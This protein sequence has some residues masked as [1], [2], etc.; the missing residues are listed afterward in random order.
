[1]PDQKLPVA[2]AA[3]VAILGAI[4][5]VL[6]FLPATTTQII[7]VVN[8]PKASFDESMQQLETGL[9]SPKPSV[10]ALRTNAAEAYRRAGQ[11]WF[12]RATNWKCQVVDLFYN[13]M[14]PIL[15]EAMPLAA[16]SDY[17]AS[18]LTPCAAHVFSVAALDWN[19]FLTL[20]AMSDGS[21]PRLD[22]I[23]HVVAQGTKAQVVGWAYL[24][25]LDAKGRY[26]IKYIHEPDASVGDTVTTAS[27]A[28]ADGV[29]LHVFPPAPNDTTSQTY[30]GGVAGFLPDGSKMTILK[31]GRLPER[32]IGEPDAYLAFAEARVVS[33]SPLLASAPIREHRYLQL[34]SRGRDYIAA[35][36]LAV[37]CPA[38]Q[39]HNSLH[40]Q[41]QL[42]IFAGET[43][44]G[45]RNGFLAGTSRLNTNCIPRD[46]Q[47][48][49]ATRDMR[50]FIGPDPHWPG[51]KPQGGVVAPGTDIRIVG[52]VAGYPFDATANPNFCSAIPVPQKTLVPIPA[53]HQKHYCVYLP[54][55]PA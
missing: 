42:W 8:R 11:A 30:I 54:F 14:D 45:N 38:Y 7:D 44:N 12:G 10:V 33:V 31:I 47:V 13:E 53:G 34:A 37:T 5:G 50:V 4:A 48:V 20:R 41:N 3:I 21:V 24:G 1:M 40:G 46:G 43:D 49:R 2:I 35:A 32:R 51:V 22:A 15:S 17:E 16:Y 39:Q 25:Q 28:T 27:E 36:Q 18:Q 29:M 26:T 6:Q 19:V 55:S 52:D 9:K 23:R